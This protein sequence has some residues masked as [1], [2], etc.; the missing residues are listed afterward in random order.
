MGDLCTLDELKNHP[1]FRRL[2]TATIDTGDEEF[3]QIGIKAVS[4]RFER[5]TGCKFSYDTYTEYFSPQDGQT[6][7]QLSAVP[8]ESI[9]SVVE[10]ATSL[11]TDAV[12]DTSLFGVDSNAGILKLRYTC[13]FPGFNTLRV[14]YVGGYN[15]IPDDL[16]YACMLQVA[17]E[18]ELASK[19]AV[20]SQQTSGGGQASYSTLEYLPAVLSILAGYHIPRFQ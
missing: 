17:H 9:T 3:I 13:F 2:R 8:V 19:T 20:S 10:S 11:W 7:V 15:I 6:S 14:V 1:S 12:M 4:R 16:K 5:Y 18:F